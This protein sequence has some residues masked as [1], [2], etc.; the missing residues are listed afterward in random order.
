[1]IKKSLSLLFLGQLL[2]ISLYGLSAFKELSVENLLYNNKSALALNFGDRP[3]DYEFF[4]AHLLEESIDIYRIIYIND[5]KITIYTSDLTF[6]GRISIN[7]GRLPNDNTNEFI[8]N[9]NT[10]EENQVGLIQNAYPNTEITICNLNS[11]RNF[12]MDGIYYVSTTDFEVLE[13]ILSE[14]NDTIYNVELLYINNKTIF[15]QI[16]LSVYSI[17]FILASVLI[18]L[19]VLVLLI[20]YSISQLKPSAILLIHG[21][22]KNKLRKIITLNTLNPLLK[23]SFIA[24]LLSIVYSAL[25]INYRVVFLLELSLYIISMCL[26]FI[27]LYTAIINIFISLYLKILTTNN[28]LKGKKPYYIVQAFNHMLKIIFIVFIFL[29]VDSSLASFKKLKYKLEALHN[30]E[31]AENIYKTVISYVG[32]Y[33]NLAIDLE[34]ANNLVLLHDQLANSNNAFII[35]SNK[36]YYLDSRVNTYFSS[37]DMPPPE[38][39][40][41]GYSIEISP[42]Y[43]NINPII[44]I[45]NE[46]AQDYIKYDDNICNI[47]VPEY[48]QPCEKDIFDEYLEYFYFNKVSVDNIY[49][50]ELGIDIN[51]TPIKDLDI[52]IIYVKNNQMYF[53]FDSRVRLEHNNMI[54][55]PIAVIYIGS[56]HPSFLS[57]NFTHSYYFYTDAIDAYNEILPH[58]LEYDLAQVIQRLVSVYDENGETIAKLHKSYIQSIIFALFLVIANIAITYSLIVNYFEKNKFKLFIKSLFGY[59]IIKRNIFFISILIIYIS[60]VTAALLPSLGF[61][62]LLFSL[63]I[64]IIDISTLLIT[65]YMLLNKSFNNNLKGKH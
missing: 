44:T 52:N 31:K 14:L 37:S 8:S 65:E 15:E 54:K 41:H 27:F 17:R 1:M 28:I 13:T 34:L 20:Q 25:S 7:N 53:S 48:L 47:L 61:K 57:S 33:D 2:A 43:L 63:L 59:S 29:T 24:Y 30:W 6:N 32:Q 51:T 62:I 9:F 40:P 42:N 10:N 11:S 38:I 50:R 60:L 45:D 16:F 26:M 12:P 5:N 23:S 39:S 36:I 19:C 46:S 22:S 55:D 49:N 18:F 3:K 64:M 35:N 21:Y 56:I 4:L 58:L